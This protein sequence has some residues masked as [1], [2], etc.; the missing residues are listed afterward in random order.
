MSTAEFLKVTVTF[1]KIYETTS[2]GH[3]CKDGHG[4]KQTTLVM[5]I[6]K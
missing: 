3:V 5:R 6:A 1:R 2:L 4:Y